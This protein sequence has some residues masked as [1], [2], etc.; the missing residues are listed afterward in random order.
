MAGILIQVVRF[1]P[2]LVL[3]KPPSRPGGPART[4]W[5]GRRQPGA[6]FRAV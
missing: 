2:Q 5:E 4:A 1:V 6:A 3:G